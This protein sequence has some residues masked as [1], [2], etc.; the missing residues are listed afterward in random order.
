MVAKIKAAI[1]FCFRKR[2][3]FLSS[4]TAWQLDENV[5]V[6]LT[7]IYGEPLAMN[8]DGSW[9]VGFRRRAT[10]EVDLLVFTGGK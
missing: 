9:E 7:W 3:S 5:H 8:A 2:A 4:V 10:G 1:C 6:R